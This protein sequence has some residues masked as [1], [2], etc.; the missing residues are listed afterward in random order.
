[1]SRANDVIVIRGG[2]PGARQERATQ[3]GRLYHTAPE[4]RVPIWIDAYG[5]PM[6]TPLRLDDLGDGYKIIF[7]FQHWC[8][9]C[10]S[11]G[12]PTL[13]RLYR[14][15]KGRG[16]GFAAIQTVFAGEAV[17]TVD[18]RLRTNQEQYGLPI[19]FGHDL[20][21]DGDRR[22]SFIEDY[23]SA[24]TPW[25]TVI[26]PSGQVVFADFRLDADRFP[27]ALDIGSLAIESA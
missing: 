2:S 22:P 16:F 14:A 17:N 26:D 5:E 10:Q 11:G 6:E 19:P 21:L 3:Y 4:L 7:A 18:T 13:Q 27:A 12:F 15:L 25:F 1:M 9:G 23:R 24:G 8:P 20:P